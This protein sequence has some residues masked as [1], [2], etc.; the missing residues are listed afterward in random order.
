MK[1]A[2][3][4]RKKLAVWSVLSILIFLTGC[5]V[6]KEPASSHP[7][8]NNWDAIGVATGPL[9]NEF[10]IP[11]GIG[12]PLMLV[13][14]SINGTSYSFILDT[15]SACVLFGPR[16]RGTLGT[17]SG[18]MKVATGGSK[19]VTVQLFPPPE[20]FLGDINL[21]DG[22]RPIVY[23]DF[24]FANDYGLPCDGII[25]MTVLCRYVVQIDYPNSTVRIMVA[26][27]KEHPEWGDYPVL[28][29]YYARLQQRPAYQR[30]YGG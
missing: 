24:D 15:G 18:E 27:N 11:K 7:W 10:V 20:A 17:P 3:G 23:V 28:E 29:A 5:N 9:N 16:L 2:D 12:T 14:V 26:D 21:Q 19:Q 13:P 22:G 1:N 30:A 6:S 8:G 4:I 25:G